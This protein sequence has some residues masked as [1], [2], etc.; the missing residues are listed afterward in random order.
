LPE[1]QET[2][3]PHR[4]PGRPREYCEPACGAAARKK[5]SHERATEAAL[6]DYAI[7]EISEDLDQKANDLVASAYSGSSAVL[8]EHRAALGR[9][10]EDLEAAVVRRGR[11]R[12]ESWDTLAADL[13]IS[14]ERLRKKWTADKVKCRLGTRT[15]RPPQDTAAAVNGTPFIPRQCPASAVAPDT[16]SVPDP[17]TDPPRHGP[18]AVSRTPHGQLTS[19]LS[20]LQRERGRT[21]RELAAFALVSAS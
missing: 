11:A 15:P 5:A 13:N 9:H 21:L 6:H 3:P 4:G 16:E 8:L 1:L 17:S 7:R 20:H 18:P 19:A 14:S 12:G 2:V 10:L